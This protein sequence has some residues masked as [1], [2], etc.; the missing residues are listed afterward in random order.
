MP[1]NAFV[2]LVAECKES[3]YLK[4]WDGSNSVHPYN[5]SKRIPI[6]LLVLTSLRYLGRG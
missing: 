6:E 5:G 3:S 2:D 1:Y 4:R